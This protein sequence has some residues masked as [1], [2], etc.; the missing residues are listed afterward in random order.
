MSEL[1]RDD[2]VIV[3]NGS[4]TDGREGVAV[5]VKDTFAYVLL[6]GEDAPRFYS[7]DDLRRIV[8]SK[9]DEERDTPEALQT[10]K[11]I[12][13]I[14]TH[15]LSTYDKQMIQAGL[16]EVRRMDGVVPEDDPA[17]AILKALVIAAKALGL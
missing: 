11:G 1:F 13:A 5:R 3:R 17:Q 9:I 4:D 15:A 16:A 6:D 10:L 14:T 12:D 8:T 2:R 7:R